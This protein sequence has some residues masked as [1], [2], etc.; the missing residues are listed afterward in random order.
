MTPADYCREK[1]AQPGSSLYYS[2][3]FLPASKRESIIAVEACFREIADVID[4][5]QEAAVARIK[6]AWWR[7]ELERAFSGVPRH[8]VSQALQ[9]AI[10]AEPLDFETFG[11]FIEGVDMQLEYERYQTFDDLRR[12]CQR[13]G[14]PAGLLSARIFGYQDSATVD[15]ARELSAAHEL[16]RI[17]RD[18]G[19]DARR[20]R[21]YLPMED[22]QRFDIPVS[23]LLNAGEA[24]GF[25]SL[26]IHQIERVEGLYRDAIAR[27]PEGD[28]VQ[29]LPVLIMAALNCTLL[30]ELRAEGAHILRQRTTLPPLR[31]LWVAWGTRRRERR[32]LRQWRRQRA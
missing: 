14:S 6:L 10:A 9:P 12:H 23:V 21:I 32:R 5:C 24:A 2:T 27:L 11:A 15:C 29:Q 3:L 13:V 28:R 1:V 18:V 31:M 4:E 16:T 7:E 25:Q 30:R 17:V 22:L 20:N 8:P 19:R 26:M